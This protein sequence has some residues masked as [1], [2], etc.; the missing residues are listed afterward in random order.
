MPVQAN[1]LTFFEDVPKKKNLISSDWV[2]SIL[3]FSFFHEPGLHGSST[4]SGDEPILWISII[5]RANLMRSKKMV[6]ADCFQQ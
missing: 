3:L 1:R 5:F 2:T 6:H 4:K